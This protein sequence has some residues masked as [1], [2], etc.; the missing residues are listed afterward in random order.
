MFI[1][2]KY[3]EGNVQSTRRVCDGGMKTADST[4]GTEKSSDEG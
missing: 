1:C 3:H 2:H 4:G